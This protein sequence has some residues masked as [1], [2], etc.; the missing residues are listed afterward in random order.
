MTVKVFDEYFEDINGTCSGMAIINGNESHTQNDHPD[1]LA[2][3]LV[4]NYWRWE[5]S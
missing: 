5:Y 3:D 1:F 4:Y 2:A